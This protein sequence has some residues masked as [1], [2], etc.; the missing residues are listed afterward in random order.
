MNK[1]RLCKFKCKGYNA[2]SLI[3]TCY[4]S[5]CADY[6]KLNYWFRRLE[7]VSNQLEYYIKKE[8]HRGGLNVNDNQRFDSLD[9][10]AR[11][12]EEWIEGKGVTIIGYK[13]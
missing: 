7:I 2:T 4:T 10:E 11:K 13:Q 9:K 6:R 3:C 5:M 1:I 12:F 8:K